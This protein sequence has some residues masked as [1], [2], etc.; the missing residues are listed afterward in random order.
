MDISNN[1]PTILVIFGGSGDLTRRKLIPA[2]Y[3]LDKQ[4]LLPGQFEIIAFARREYTAESFRKYLKDEVEKMKP[5]LLDQVTWNRF[6]KRVSY[7]RGDFSDMEAY[8]TLADRLNEIDDSLGVC[9]HKI[10]H[11]AISPDFFGQVFEGLQQTQLSQICENVKDTRVVIEK[12]FGRD[13]ASFKS[14]NEK[15]LSVFE[16]SQIYRI[17]HYLGKETVQNLLYFRAANPFFLDDWDV[18]HIRAIKI[19]VYESLGVGTRGSYYDSYGHLR[20]MVQSHI[21]QL[22]ALVLMQLPN[23]FDHDKIRAAKTEVLKNLRAVEIIRGQYKEGVVGGKIV[24][25]YKEENDVSEDSDTETFV[26]IRAKVG[27][28]DWDGLELDI[29]SG[30]RMKEKNSSIIVDY[31]PNESIKGIKGSNTLIFRL[32][33][34]EGMTLKLQVKKPTS[35]RLDEVDMSFNYKESFQTILPDAYEKIM[36]DVIRLRRSLFLGTEELKASWTFVDSIL[37]RWENNADDLILY[38]A[39]SNELADE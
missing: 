37:K 22:V 32:Q 14:L 29:V 25:G 16:E 6:S 36:L 33:P 9:T 19:H 11:L 18:K 39:G 17:D 13:L 2:L 1:Q 27:G 21:L 31:K 34:H 12:P 35:E 8:K 23:E 5:R 38:P 15:V 20:D 28:G 10:F 30:K 7:L 26:K 24:V 4:G 3:N